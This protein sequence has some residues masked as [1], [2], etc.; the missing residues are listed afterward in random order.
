MHRFWGGRGIS[1]GNPMPMSCISFFHV[2]E[3]GMTGYADAACQGICE[4]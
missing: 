1:P 4:R 3:R 2:L